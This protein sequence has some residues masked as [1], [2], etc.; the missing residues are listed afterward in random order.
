MDIRLS[1]LHGKDNELYLVYSNLSSTELDR[2][3]TVRDTVALKLNYR[4]YL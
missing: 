1:L 3:R 4:L 2:F